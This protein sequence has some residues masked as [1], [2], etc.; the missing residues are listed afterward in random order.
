MTKKTIADSLEELMKETA[1]D[2]ITVQMI[3][4][5]APVSRNAFYYHFKSKQDVLEW[6]C[7]DYFIHQCLPYHKFAKDGLGAEMILKYIF[8]HKNF[9]RAIYEVDNGILLHTCL[10]KAHLIATEEENAREYGHIDHTHTNRVR[11]EVYRV[12]AVS[13]VVGV[14]VWWVRD[15][16]SVP[17]E[18]MAASL[19]MMLSERLG[20][21]RDHYVY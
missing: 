15:N 1:Y 4:K 6:Q 8:E 3:C 5:R 10:M 21:I 12:Y 18:E 16:Y 14:L 17:T 9:Y 11:Q 2:Q 7:R 19:H 20:I 13:G